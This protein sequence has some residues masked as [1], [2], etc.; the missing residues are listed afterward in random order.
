[1]QKIIF[2]I[3]LAACALL[4]WNA[5][6]ARQ[7]AVPQDWRKINADGY[8]TFYLPS[9]MKQTDM[10]GV[11]SFMR[12]Y[13]D[14]ERRFLFVYLPYSHLAYDARR[15][16]EMEDYHETKT[17]ISGRK[18]VI[19]T[20]HTTDENAYYSYQKGQTT[21]VAELHVG[22]WANGQVELFMSLEAKSSAAIETARQIF[23]TVEMLS[24]KDMTKTAEVAEVPLFL[25]SLKNH[26]N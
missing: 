26:A 10:A 13:I 16:E 6:S 18:A 20:Y 12:E 25:L 14:G 8:F 15:S 11:E 22:D 17:E 23:G 7:T 21:Y 2:V 1:M 5:A 4:T 24:G 19:R 9:S 3:S